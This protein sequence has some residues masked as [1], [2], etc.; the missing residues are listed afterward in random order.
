MALLGDNPPILN[1]YM[2]S[3]A[4][5]TN[6]FAVSVPSQNGRVYRLEFVNSPTETNWTALPL[7]AGTGRTL[8]LNDPSATNSSSRFYRVRR[9]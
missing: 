2:S 3:A 7:V 4:T 9:W 1:A 8:Q 6:G 5:T